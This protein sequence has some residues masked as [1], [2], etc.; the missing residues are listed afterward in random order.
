MIEPLQLQQFH[1]ESRRSELAANGFAAKYIDFPQIFTFSGFGFGDIKHIF[2]EVFA[3]ESLQPQKSSWVSSRTE[4]FMPPGISP[5]D[6]VGVSVVSSRVIYRSQSRA[7]RS[8]TVSGS[9]SVRGNVVSIGDARRTA[10]TTKPDPLEI[11]CDG[12]A[13]ARGVRSAFILEAGMA[14]LGC[15]AWLLWHLAR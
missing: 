3:G 5:S 7:V 4:E 1:T 14:L 10:C 8:A 11:D 12:L 15:A 6:A 9:N 2:P 13:C